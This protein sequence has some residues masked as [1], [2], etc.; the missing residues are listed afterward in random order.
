MVITFPSSQ[1]NFS[2]CSSTYG[3]KSYYILDDN[4]FSSPLERVLLLFRVNVTGIGKT[5][6]YEEN[7]ATF[8]FW[9]SDVQVRSL[10]PIVV[11]TFDERWWLS[12]TLLHDGCSLSP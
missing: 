10:T 11:I 5:V 8:S 2:C 1:D 4:L 6:I 7:T 3:L 12:S 9:V